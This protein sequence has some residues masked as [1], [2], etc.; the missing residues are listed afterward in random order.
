[1]STPAQRMS[2]GDLYKVNSLLLGSHTDPLRGHLRWDPPRSLWNVGIWVVAVLLGPVTATWDSALIFMSM[3][4]LS[5]CA[6]HSVGF[7]RRLIASRRGQRAG[8]RLAAVS[9]PNDG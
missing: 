5:L 7:H 1:M 9:N 4:A 8:P 6:G 2:R 3:T